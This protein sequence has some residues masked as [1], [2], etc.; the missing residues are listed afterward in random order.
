MVRKEMEIIFEDLS[1]REKDVIRVMYFGK[2]ND[3]G[4]SEEYF[5][6][7]L[8]GAR[9]KLESNKWNKKRLRQRS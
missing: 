6:E 4:L 1:P 8:N 5:L 9:S 3:L 2:K 7:V